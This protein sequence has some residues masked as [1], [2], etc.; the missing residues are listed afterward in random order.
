M[1]DHTLYDRTPL[2]KTLASADKISKELV[3]DHTM[4]ENSVDGQSS[5]ADTIER[6]LEKTAVNFK[7]KS[8]QKSSYCHAVRRIK[9]FSGVYIYVYTVWHEESNFQIQIERI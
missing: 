8:G 3:Y 1:Y 5:S 4:Y 6:H 7:N 2:S 9:T